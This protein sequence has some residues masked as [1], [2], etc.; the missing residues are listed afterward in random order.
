MKI[1]QL[2]VLMIALLAFQVFACFTFLYSSHAQTSPD[3]YVGVDISYG[4][5]AEA[6]AMIDQVSSFTNLFVVGT[7]KITWYPN[8]LNET[9][10]Y[11]YEKGLSFISLPPALPTYSSAL[12]NKTEWYA[13]AENR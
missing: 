4:D 10:D 2:T 11:A 9:F 1:R 8:K 12:V 5:V 13:Y 7:S 6:K 3:V